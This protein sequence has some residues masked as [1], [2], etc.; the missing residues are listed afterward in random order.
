MRTGIKAKQPSTCETFPNLPGQ[1]RLWH[2]E[3]GF[4]GLNLT[5]RI[6]LISACFS[7]A[8]V[9]VDFTIARGLWIA[10]FS[11]GVMFGTMMLPAT[12]IGMFMLFT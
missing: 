10:V 6:S 2:E 3:G 11:L 4:W 8:L 9:S 5:T 7:H 12:W 1:R